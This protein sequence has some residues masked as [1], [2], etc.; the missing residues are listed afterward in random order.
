MS[1]HFRG[2]EQQQRALDA[3][4]KLL[5]A[6]NSV[7]SE[8]GEHVADAGLT[9]TQFAVLEALHHVGPMCLGELARKILKSGG[10]LT[11]V[12]DNLEKRGLAR[13]AQQ[14]KDRRFILAEITPKGRKL[15]EQIFPEHVRNIVAAM[16]RLSNAEQE[17]LARL[18]RK[19]G[20]RGNGDA[21]ELE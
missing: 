17:T 2:S 10:N 9:G 6:A 21:P 5:R 15:I 20:L 8:V 3:Y 7:S 14:G 19:V 4:V 16:G 13:R 18:C 11:L 1:K 12:I